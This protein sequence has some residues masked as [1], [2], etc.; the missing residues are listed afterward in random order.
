MS[1]EGSIWIET[2]RVDECGRK[3]MDRDKESG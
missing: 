1:V 2:R 3:L